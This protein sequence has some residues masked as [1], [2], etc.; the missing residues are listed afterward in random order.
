M[1]QGGIREMMAIALP[2]VVS[3]GCD[4][5]MIFTDR[6]F[7]SRLG[8]ELMNAA[9]GGGLTAYLMI[10]F[11]MGLVGYTTALSAQYLGAG[12]RDRSA[13]VLTQ[14]LI[15]VAVAGPVILVL[16]P[17][18]HRWFDFMNVPAGQA[19]PQKLYFDILVYG[20]ALNLTRHAF[21][22]FF[23]GVGRTRIVMVASLIS[24][25]ANIFFN[26]VLIYGKFGF[27]AWG[28]AGAAVGTILGNAVGCL[29][30]LVSYLGRA[31]R[32]EFAVA[33]SLVF[34]AGVMKKLL[35]YGTPAG[36]ETA[37]NI[38]AFN[39][40]VLTF[41]S[42]GTVTATAST[43]MF[44]WDLVSFVPLLGVEI[45]VTSLVGRYMGASDP[46]T[47]E[48]AVRSGLKMGIAYSGI[49]FAG[50]V[51]FPEVLVNVFRPD[52]ADGVFA[53]AF[54][55]AVWMLRLAALYVFVDAVMVVF[56]GALRGAGDTLWA[57]GLTTS[58]HWLS[59]LLLVLFLKVFGFSVVASWLGV[60][61]GF[62]AASTLVFWRYKSGAWKRL[63]V[64]EAA[65][66]AG[67]AD[68][69]GRV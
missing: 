14:A 23:S 56:V 69:Q 8:P 40:M 57:M 5:F 20:A 24:M 53:Q 2:M 47:A 21:S 52:I 22:S 6:M 28:I 42:M 50:F 17:L 15:I 62:L 10:T 9:L 58:L 16:S 54:G 11:F 51:L 18:A 13:V 60:I 32:L 66:L 44:N 46:K 25:S 59:M 27:P 43:V 49:I 48:R 38:L 64:V 37:L 31:N 67:G 30:L 12:Q 41:H 68:P 19:A 63:R 3:Y 61:L 1:K 45:G 55:T 34:S 7:L 65:P 33:R 26:Y 39:A 35:R 36:M 29:I 4:T